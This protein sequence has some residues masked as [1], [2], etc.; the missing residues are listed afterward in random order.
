MQKLKPNLEDI[1]FADLKHK[2]RFDFDFRPNS[3]SSRALSDEIGVLNL[4]KLRLKGKLSILGQNGWLLKAHLGASVV[5]NCV[6]SLQP[7]K[8]RIDVRVVRK[9]LKTSE[10]TANTTGDTENI[11]LKQDETTEPL[12]T[13]VNLPEV[14][15]E[16]LLLELPLYPKAKN[17][18]LNTVTF[19]EVN[20]KKMVDEGNKPFAKLATL[21]DK[22]M[23]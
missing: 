20:V 1:L 11:C 2:K 15:K 22:L 23:K 14:L 19:S 6:I 3:Q 7:I 5:Q 12:G 17:A 4:S 9:F 8:T 21:K 13:G 10:T 18:K 16:A